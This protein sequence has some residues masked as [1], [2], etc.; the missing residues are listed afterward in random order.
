MNKQR[1]TSTLNKA[2]QVCLEH[3]RK[4]TIQRK[5]ILQILLTT[6]VPLSA[7]ELV[8]CYK[9]RTSSSV[10]VMSVY[11]ILRFLESVNLVRRLNSANKYIAYDAGSESFNDDPS[12]FLICRH[13][14]KVETLTVSQSDVATLFPH[15]AEVGFTSQTTQ[16][17]M[18]G[19]CNEC[20]AKIA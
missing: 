10:S 5:Q 4:F 19:V 7:Y 6:D 18:M 15:F 9:L 13:C 16:F 20:Q 12:L 1:L 14:Q 17:E 8:S 2:K 11:R 3:G